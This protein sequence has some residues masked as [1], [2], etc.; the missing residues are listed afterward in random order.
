MCTAT[1]PTLLVHPAHQYCV[2][3][4][5]LDLMGLQAMC[6]FS[7]FY[8]IYLEISTNTYLITNKVHLDMCFL[9]LPL[10]DREHHCMK[11]AVDPQ[12]LLH[13]SIKLRV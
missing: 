8:A 4:Y 7:F 11:T 2:Q 3:L 6:G 10:P 9:Q 1:D 12:L 13:L 5:F